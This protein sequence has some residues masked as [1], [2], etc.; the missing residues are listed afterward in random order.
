VVAQW[1]SSTAV[2]LSIAHNIIQKHTQLVKENTS[3]E[4][5]YYM[6]LYTLGVSGSQAAFF[7]GSK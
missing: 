3:L 6:R 4:C 5:T 2:T 1:Q 7:S